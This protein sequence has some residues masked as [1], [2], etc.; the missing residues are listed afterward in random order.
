MK[1]QSLQIAVAD[2]E[3][4]VRDYLKRVLERMGHI[5]RGPI[6]NGLRL[7]ELRQAHSPDLVITD[8]RMSGLIGDEAL[9]QIHPLHPVPCI[10]VSAHGCGHPTWL[11]SSDANWA[12]LDKPFQKND[13]REAIRQLMS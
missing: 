6:E 8:I 9:R 12:F 10:V 2:D 4:V 3:P 11:E 7:V 5:V 1:K 13:L